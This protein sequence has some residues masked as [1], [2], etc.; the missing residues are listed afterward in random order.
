MLS[1]GKMAGGQERYYLEKVAEGAEDWTGR[2]G[3]DRI[4]GRAADQVFYP[5]T[6]DGRARR[7]WKAHNLAEREAAEE[8]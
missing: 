6:I 2:T 8:E 1:I 7:A 5:S 3:T 4:F